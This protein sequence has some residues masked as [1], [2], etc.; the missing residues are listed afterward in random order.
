M[1]SQNIQNKCLKWKWPFYACQTFQE[2][3]GRKGHAMPF[4][5]RDLS[6]D[7]SILADEMLKEFV[8]DFEPRILHLRETLSTESMTIRPYF[9]GFLLFYSAAFSALWA[10]RFNCGAE[11]LFTEKRIYFQIH[12]KIKRFKTTPK[13]TYHQEVGRSTSRS[14]YSLLNVNY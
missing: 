14:T 9:K 12:R 13:W 8:A 3:K 6:E 4:L 2:V 10:V 7:L 1:S 5:H 11:S